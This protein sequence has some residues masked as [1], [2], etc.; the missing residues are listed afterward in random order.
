MA[1][2]ARSRVLSEFQAGQLV[3]YYR[4]GK[5]NS[6]RGYRGPAK[7]IAVDKGQ[8]GTPMVAWLSHAGTLIRAAPEHLRMATT[9]E[10]RTYDI[11]A[12]SG[13]ITTKSMDGSR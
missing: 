10:T 5:R 6:D 11:L 1:A 12:D 13:T 7:V 3:H 2:R 8:G 9:L 4:R